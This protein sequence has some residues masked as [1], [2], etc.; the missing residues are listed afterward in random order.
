MSLLGAG[1]LISVLLI[2]QAVGPTGILSGYTKDRLSVAGI[3]LLC[4]EEHQEG[5]HKHDWVNTMHNKTYQGGVP[6]FTAPSKQTKRE[7]GLLRGG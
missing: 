4:N 1:P 5:F 7:G 6:C 3:P 2:I